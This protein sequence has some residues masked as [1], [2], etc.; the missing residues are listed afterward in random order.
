[1][2]E[3]SWLEGELRALA[4]DLSPDAGRPLVLAI[5]QGGHASRAL[6]FDTQGRQLAEAF[7]P[8]STFRQG[9]DRVE[10]DAGEILE[11]VRTALNDVRHA[12]GEE[13]PRVIRAGLATQ[14]AS[15]ACWDRRTGQALSPVLSWQDRR[16]AALVERLRTHEPTIRAQTGLPLSPHYGASKLR[17]C[18]DEISA[19]QEAQRGH[20]L[21]LGPIASFLV[22][23][24]LEERTYVADPATAARTQLWDLA[25][26]DWSDSLTALFGVPRESLPR[27]VPTYHAYGQMSF[28]EQRIPFLVST[29]DQSAAPFA[30]GPMDGNTIYLNV[31]TGAFLQRMHGVGESD[32]ARLLRSVLWSDD[33]ST[34]S[35]VEATV[36]GAGSAIDWLNERI[37]IDTHRA[38][39]SMSRQS[40][41]RESPP[42]FLNGISGVGSP[43]WLAQAQSRFLSEAPEALQ[44]V[45]VVESIAF[46]IAANIE[47]MRSASIRRVLA[48]GG[49]SASDYLC[50]C[51]ASLS[52]LAVERTSLRESTATGLAFLVAG[53]PTDWQPEGEMT[54]FSPEPDPALTE[55]YATFCQAMDAEAR[56]RP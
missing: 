14:R 12:L 49:L 34:L 10:H 20:R 24:L 39:L 53:Q 27:C 1:M 29:G 40:V 55:R 28:G 19:V 9:S 44:V 33:R 11:S 2:S 38:A 45:A 41:G 4:N 22:A 50:E 54:R 8:I 13:A 18:L 25:G 7:A 51:V 32:D 21:A 26:R 17:W 16:N 5:D 30:A 52:G 31:G 37:G 48:S 6:V 23:S 15:T 47:R 46:L 35:V 36:N 43:W 42:V 56:E 3:L